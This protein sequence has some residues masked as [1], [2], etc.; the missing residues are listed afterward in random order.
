MFYSKQVSIVAFKKGQ[1][2]VKAHSWDRSLGGRDLDNVL[3][4]HFAGEF[5]AK[6]GLDVLK[7]VKAIYRLRT[8]IEKCRC[9]LTS[10]PK[11]PMDVECLMEDLD[12]RCVLTR[13]KLLL[14]KLWL[15]FPG[16]T[17][18]CTC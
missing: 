17:Q 10:N 13:L 14:V 11:A 6:H 8:Q 12:F 18:E 7:N 3:L 16:L 2:E 15:V 5:K 9:Q 4:E 1:M